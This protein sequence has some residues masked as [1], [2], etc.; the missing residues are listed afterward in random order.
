MEE[1]TLKKLLEEL[2]E[3]VEAY[4]KTFYTE[5]PEIQSMILL[6][7]EHTKHVIEISKDLANALK[8][9]KH[10]CILAEMIGLFHDIGRFKQYSIYQTFNDKISEN[11][12]LLGLEEIKNLT[13]LNRLSEA[14]LQT[15]RFAIE[16]HN[17]MEIAKTDN[18]RN[19]LFAKIIRDADKLDIYRV[20][21]P[22]LKP[23]DG[24]GYNQE[25]MELFLQ[26]RQCDYSLIK[27][28]DDQKLVRLLWMYDIY[29][30]WT[31]RKIMERGYVEQIVQYLPQDEITRKGVERLKMHMFKIAN[32][33]E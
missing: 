3:W 10:D 4:I 20:L 33:E 31:M 30:G 14:D 12:S 9:N 17:A 11:H 28:H 26:G 19:Q 6:K 16:N 32:N 1:S 2:Y 29:F 27:T 18:L 5:D 21:S 15:F 13:L 25:F 8:L 22:M 23:S 24:S 7:E